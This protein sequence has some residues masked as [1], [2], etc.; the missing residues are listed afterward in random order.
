MIAIVKR[1]LGAYFSSPVG[2]VYLG[3]FYLLTGYFFFA[4]V[5]FANSSVMTPVFQ[6]MINIVMFLTPVLTMRLM[7]EDRRHRTDQVLLTA[8]VSLGVIAGGKFLAAA[9]VYAA[10][11]SMTLVYSVVVEVLARVNQVMVWGNSYVVNWATVWGSYIGI[12]LLGFAF[13]A[14]GQFISSLTENQAIA[15]IGCFTVVL[16]IFLMDALIDIVPNP[17]VRTI[18]QGI[19]FMRRY[20]PITNGILGIANLVFFASVCGIFLFLTTRVLEKRRW[21]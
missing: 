7:S 19:S 1:E 2:Y 5:L 8:P 17:L 6:V 15:A 20:T 11:V 21:S 14:I 4:G 16:A 10:G 9:V 12:L 18:L 3:V 13:I